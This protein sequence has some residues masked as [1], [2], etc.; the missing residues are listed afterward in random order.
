MGETVVVIGE[1]SVFSG[2]I[3]ELRRGKR[4]EIFSETITPD[5]NNTDGI[6]DEEMDVPMASRTARKNDG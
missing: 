6:A 1:Q 4:S 2:L 5:R 3:Y